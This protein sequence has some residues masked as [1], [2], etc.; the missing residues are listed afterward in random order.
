[1]NS[2]SVIHADF[3][4]RQIMN[5]CLTFNCALL[6]ASITVS[7][8][9]LAKPIDPGVKLVRYDDLDLS[10]AAGM[11]AL[12]RRIEAALDWVCLDPNGPSPAGAVN[13]ACK[14]DG[15]RDAFA[16][17]ANVVAQQKSARA[18]AEAQHATALPTR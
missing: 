6:M 12:H 3:Q 7:S 2:Q 5:R 14:I 11:K 4:R 17:V 13:M 15:R 16:Q 18:V 1:V 8:I 10:T 9:S